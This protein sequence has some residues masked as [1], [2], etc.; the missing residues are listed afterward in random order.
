MSTKD[1]ILTYAKETFTRYGIK[2]IPT[3]KIVSDLGISKKTLYQLFANKSILVQEV[4]QS[5]VEEE[6]HACIG[7]ITKSNDAIDELMQLIRHA[8]AMFQKISPGMIY[9]VRKF[10]PEAWK[11][12]EKHN[13]EFLLQKVAENL[14]RGIQEG[15]YRRNINVDIVSRVRVSSIN[16]GFDPH[17]FPES[18]FNLMDVHL[19]LFELYLYGIV[20]DKGRQLLE[21]YLLHEPYYT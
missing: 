9:E 16:T 21:K 11:I 20:T 19:Q 10:Y 13:G 4:C 17:I 1:R 18:Q 7:I 6:E 3:D 14:K 15:V 5:L 2:A 12:V 8:I